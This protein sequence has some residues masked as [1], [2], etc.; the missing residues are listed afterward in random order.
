MTTIHKR[1]YLTLALLF[2]ATVLFLA[3]WY[4][5][6]HQ[7]E[8]REYL[9]SLLQQQEETM[10]S[11]SYLVDRDEADQTVAEL[12]QDCPLPERQRFDE[13]LSSLSQL[14]RVEL[15]EIDTLF[16]HCG[17]FYIDRQKILTMRL[18]R[19]L[20]V[21]QNYIELLKLTDSESESYMKKAAEWQ[22][23]AELESE[24]SRL[25]TELVSLQEQI[26]GLLISGQSVRS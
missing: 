17:T 8:Y 11:L 20:A 15:T 14:S 7:A 3:S 21:Y 23:L 26:I 22:I 16:D 13:L 6:S 1:Y 9:Y 25:A 5:K 12:V 19:E 24:R 4:V 2:I 10:A 18:Q